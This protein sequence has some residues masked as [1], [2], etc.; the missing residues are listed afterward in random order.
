MATA[1]QLNVGACVRDM[2]TLKPYD[3]LAK[4]SYAYFRIRVDHLFCVHIDESNNVRSQS[5]RE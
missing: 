1:T 5:Y 3:I 4:P 2:N